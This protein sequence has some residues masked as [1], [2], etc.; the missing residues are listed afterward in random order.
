M[1]PGVVNLAVRQGDSYSMLLTLSNPSSSDPRGVTP[2]TPIDLTGC[3]AEMQIRDL[4]GNVQLSLS[5]ASAT[6]NGSILT[7]GGTAGTINIAIDSAD[8][9]ALV[10]GVYDLRVKFANESILTFV[11]GTVEVTKGVTTWQ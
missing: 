6:E 10:A 1:K 7:L 5:S 4:Y 8:T 3:V 11:A 2:G 9:L